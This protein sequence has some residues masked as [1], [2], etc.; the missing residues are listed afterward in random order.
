MEKQKSDVVSFC[1]DIVRI[2]SQPCKESKVAKRILAEMEEL[3][4]DSVD[5]DEFGSVVGLIQRGDGPTIVVDAHMDTVGV[6]PLQDW[7]YDPYGAWLENG[8]IYGR[9]TIDM[10][11]PLAA[12]V[13][14]LADLASDEEFRGTVVASLS[15]MEEKS[16]GVALA[17]VLDKYPA[18]FLIIAEPTNL[19]L[20][21]AQKGRAELSLTTHGL[22]T[23][24]ST[25]QFGVDAVMKMMKLI[26]ALYEMPLPEHPFLGKG[27]LAL[28]DIISE[29]YPA[30]S[31]VPFICKATFDRR[32]VSGETE[33]SV[34][35]E[36]QEVIDTLARNDKDFK[37][38][39]AIAR[40]NYT[41]YTGKEFEFKKFLKSWEMPEDTPAIAAAQTALSKVQGKEV[42]LTSYNFCTNGSLPERHESIPTLGFGPGKEELAHRMNEYILVDDLK[43]GARCYP[44]LVKAIS[45]I[46][47][48]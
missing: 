48:S 6:E 17:N 11:G 42:E 36:V 38:E 41:A 2:P 15:T 30:I 39:A 24:S 26:S 37:A 21:R 34:L 3:N 14:G 13:Y 10:K 47:S 23:H 29:P 16:E 12:V 45:G 9:G 40:D 4:Y 27:V 1:Q 22:T 19:N 18:D 44:E 8:K 20:A 32:L 28:T 31:M 25:P 43:L 33:T 35:K 46:S 7:D 5:I